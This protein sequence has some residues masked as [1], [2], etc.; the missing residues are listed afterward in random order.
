MTS[1]GLM[2]MPGSGKSTLFTALTRQAVAPQFLG[3]DLKPH[4]AVVKIPDSRLLKLAEYY[5][6]RS[7]VNATIEFVD[8]PGFDP[9]T[10]EA[11]LKNA[12]LEHYRRC[13]ALALVVDM[14]RPGAG[15]QAA[16]TIGQLIDELNLLGLVTA[17]SARKRLEKQA[18]M[19]DKD[20]LPRY[21]LL[22]EVQAQLEEGIPL[23]RMELDAAQAKLLREYAFLSMLPMIVV[24]NLPDDSFIDGAAEV[25]GLSAAE[26]FAREQ[27]LE[28]I[29]LSAALEA[30]LAGM[31][32]DE[33]AEYMAEFG[34]SEPVLPRMIRAAYDSL[35]LITFLTGSEKECRAWSIPQGYTAQQA[36]GTIH[37]DMARGFIRAETISYDDFIACG[38]QAGAKAEGKLRLEGKDYTVNDGDILSIRFNV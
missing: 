32:G 26:E 15:E 12:V 16:G 2:G 11:K 24:F 9:A 6:T 14:F 19:K 22:G 3:Y 29:R 27:G 36:A 13:D 31:D 1:I 21:E 7:I 20:A 4:Q 33:A 23:R 28:S 8:I 10:T 35:G 34:V 18:K 30:E 5:D 37:S 38:G 17:E 25:P